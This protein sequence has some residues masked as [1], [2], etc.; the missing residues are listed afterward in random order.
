MVVS[1]FRY[2]F[3]NFTGGNFV[4]MKM[5]ITKVE[6]GDFG[7]YKCFA[8]NKEGQGESFVNLVGKCR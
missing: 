6:P 8:I 1:Y 5:R 3:E 4:L 2:I 7:Q